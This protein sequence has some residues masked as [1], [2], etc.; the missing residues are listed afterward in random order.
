MQL[1]SETESFLHELEVFSNRKLLFRTEVGTLVDLAAQS[2]RTEL[3]DD[4][5]FY[6]K[7]LTKTFDIIKRIGKDGEGYDKLASEFQTTLEKASTLLKTIV[8]DAS[9]EEKR[10]FVDLFFGMD[11]ESLSLLLDLMRDLSWV[12]NWQVDGKPIPYGSSG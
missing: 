8:K 3:L 4:V 9:E 7:F 1:R 10:H 2:K 12:K 11:Q 5:I 6:A